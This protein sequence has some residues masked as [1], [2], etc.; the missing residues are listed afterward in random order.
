KNEGSEPEQQGL[1]KRII[2]FFTEAKVELSRVIWPTKKET[3][4]STWR[5]LILVILAG[6]FLALID[7]IWSKI[8]SWII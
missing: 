4:D 6:I 7:S 5:L 8:L 1:I 2:T 3:V